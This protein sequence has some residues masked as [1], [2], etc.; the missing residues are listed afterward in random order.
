MTGIGDSMSKILNDR[1]MKAVEILAG[2][3]S[4]S[5]AA[6]AAGVSERTLRRWRADREEFQDALADANE[7]AYADLFG[8]LRLLARHASCALKDVL[9]DTDAPAHVRVR[10]AEIVISQAVRS[11]ECTRVADRE[12]ISNSIL[13]GFRI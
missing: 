6:A 7:A 1:E 10:A 9:S 12:R 2:G 3:A 5:V 11:I 8:D 4:S 13:D